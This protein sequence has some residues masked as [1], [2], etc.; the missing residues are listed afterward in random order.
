MSE[1][2]AEKVLRNLLVDVSHLKELINSCMPRIVELETAVYRGQKRPAS[3]SQ[4]YFS[5]SVRPSSGKEI[6]LTVSWTDRIGEIKSQLEDHPPDQWGLRFQ[7]IRL[8]DCST[9][10]D[11]GIRPDDTID[12]VPRLSRETLSSGRGVWLPFFVK[13]TGGQVI[14]LE[15]KST[16]LI[17]AV[18]RGIQDKDGVPP[19]QQRLVFAG[20]QLDDF[21]KL[22]DYEVQ[23]WS[24]V[25]LVLRQRG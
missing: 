12:L 6:Y 21:D 23:P 25:Y 7:G 22:A 10:V 4:E 11:S 17:E 20:K 8:E 16:D 3:D 24:V 2:Q 15:M 13:T 9:V 5:I 14:A 19:D 1:A 18:K